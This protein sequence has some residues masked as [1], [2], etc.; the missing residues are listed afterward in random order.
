MNS[1]SEEW[2]SLKRPMDI[3]YQVSITRVYDTRYT[4][5]YWQQYT[6][7][8]SFLYRYFR[9][10]FLYHVVLYQHVP[11]MSVLRGRASHVRVPRFRAL[12]ICR[13]QQQQCH[14]RHQCW[15]SS[16]KSMAI[17]HLKRWAEKSRSRSF[18]RSLEKR[19]ISI[20]TISIL[21]NFD[22]F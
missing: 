11:G 17:V 7:A 18:A 13:Q 6:I 19:V 5:W 9:I 1:S 21:A 22:R 8:F 4:E 15:R 16:L 10:C 14:T 12:D 2:I 20:I 3:A